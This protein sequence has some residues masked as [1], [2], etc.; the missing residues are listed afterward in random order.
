MYGEALATAYVAV[1]GV[2]AV[3]DFRT[4]RAPNRIVYPATLAGMIASIPLGGADWR[5][6]WLGGAAA[7]A[8]MTV[9]YLAGRGAMGAG[10]AKTSAIAGLAV[11]LHGVFTM[12]VATFLA[13]AA[14]ALVLL[15]LRLRDR[16]DTTAFTPFMFIGVLV[17]LALTPGYLLT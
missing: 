1:L 14:V 6:A 2:I 17:S 12:L 13:G 5:E 3:I 10:D 11:G 16:K 7:F 15:A 4:R 8:V 9:I